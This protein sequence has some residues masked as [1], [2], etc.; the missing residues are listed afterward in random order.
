M[1]GRPDLALAAWGRVPTSDPNFVRAAES[2][3][4]VLINEARF[5]PAEAILWAVPFAIAAIGRYPLCA[6]WADYSGF[7]VD[8]LM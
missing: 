6:C 7:R 1:L 8:G 5:A 3:G 4:S 2:R